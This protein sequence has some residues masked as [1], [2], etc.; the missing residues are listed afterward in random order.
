MKT[1]IYRRVFN[2]LLLCLLAG[3]GARAQFGSDLG[4]PAVSTLAWDHIISNF[5]DYESAA[6]IGL[7]TDNRM[8]VWGGN[9]LFT[10]NNKIR[11]STSGA[12]NIPV[13]QLVPTYVP[14]PAG[15]TI[16]KVRLMTMNVSGSGYHIPTYLALS[17]SG[18]LY[19]WGINTGAVG[20]AWVV[21]N[22]YV[23]PADWVDTTKT[24]R[25]PVPL[26][27]LG[28]SSFVDMD[29]S[30]LYGYWIAIGASGKAYHNGANTNNAGNFQTTYA[31]LPN[32]AGV[33]AS[34]FKYTNVWVAP[35]GNHLRIYLKGNNGN[36][37]YTGGYNQLYASGVPS[38]YNIAATTTAQI[39]GDVRTL[40]PILVPFPAG[41][42]IVD[43]KFDNISNAKSSNYAISASGKA[44]IAG[45][46]RTARSPGGG[47]A[48]SFNTYTVTPIKT[49]PASSVLVTEFIPN[50]TTY[51]LKEFTEIAT[52]PGATKIIDIELKQNPS[53]PNR[54]SLVIGDNN[55]VYWSGTTVAG[56][57]DI[58]MSGNYLSNSQAPSG[59]GLPD[60]C[61]STEEVRAN[62]YYAWNN[63]AINY[64]G[65]AKFFKQTNSKEPFAAF[66]ISKTGRGYF[67]GGFNTA[68][69]LGKLHENS[70]TLRNYFPVP[71]ANEQLLDCQTSPGT[72]GPL[73]A[74]TAPTNTAV[75]TIDCSKTKLYPAPVAGVPSQLSLIVTVNVTTIGNFTPITVS[76]SGM[77]LPSGFSSVTATTTGVQTFHIPLSYDGS[78]LTNAF[79]FTVGSAGSCSA[80]LTQ[81]SNPVITN[82]WNLTNCSAITPGVLSK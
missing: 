61:F 7:T 82:V 11:R 19:G 24:V 56:T 74:V 75:G 59:T 77:S 3:T 45:H 28:E 27:I 26:T 39:N 63:E 49:A 40:V 64:R 17:Q 72:G 78:A 44:Y 62:S 1:T 8:Y 65:A 51:Y 79:Q 58:D 32:P 18:K 60:L 23:A 41:E 42:N 10:I 37:Y 15:E 69:G 46:W 13:M 67:V 43:M 34:T 71:I 53:G 81:K 2:I 20:T 5:N 70:G 52:P 12:P 80:D 33:S 38:L 48:S 16:K 66:I 30:R 76:G 9:A 21:K 22:T 50:D 73:T 54:Q 47:G 6:T 57:T 31:A 4:A 29:A 68:S 14:S 25:T 55:K 35:S 36:I